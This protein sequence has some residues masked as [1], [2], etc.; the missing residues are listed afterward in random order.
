[1]MWWYFVR[2]A[3]Q[4]TKYKYAY[5]FESKETTGE[6]EY[7]TSNGKMTILQY[8]KGRSDTDFDR[9]QLKYAACLLIKSHG[10]PEERMIAYG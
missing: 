5:G 1:M 6:F 9:R 7:D 2:L 8:A 4:G 10:A 3:V